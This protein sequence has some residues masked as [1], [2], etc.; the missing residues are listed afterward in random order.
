MDVCNL[1]I[2]I[3]VHEQSSVTIDD[4]SVLKVYRDQLLFEFENASGAVIN[5]KYKEKEEGKCEM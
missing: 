3:E 5:Q 4:E 2:G 1:D